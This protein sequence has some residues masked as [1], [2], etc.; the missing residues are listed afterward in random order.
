[1][2]LRIVLPLYY[3]KAQS[4]RLIVPFSTLRGSTK[5]SVIFVEVVSK[6]CGILLPFKEECRKMEDTSSFLF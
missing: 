6:I 4:L 2:V 5:F 3:S 1:M